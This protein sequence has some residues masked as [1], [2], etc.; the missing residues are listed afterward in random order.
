M[1]G[2]FESWV[3]GEVFTGVVGRGIFSGAF[4]IGFQELGGLEELAKAIL[5]II[6]TNSWAHT[7]KL[8]NCG[9]Y[10]KRSFLCS[11][12]TV[13]MRIATLASCFL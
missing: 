12:S 9:W 1:G 3:L 8:E 2:A 7:Y 5:V 11:C 6:S 10:I 13:V 4:W